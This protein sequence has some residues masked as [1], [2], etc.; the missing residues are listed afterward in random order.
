MTTQVLWNDVDFVLKAPSAS[1]R[2][3]V[4]FDED[5]LSSAEDDSW[6][7]ALYEDLDSGTEYLSSDNDEDLILKEEESYLLDQNEDEDSDD[8]SILSPQTQKFLL[9]YY[10]QNQ[11]TQTH[12]KSHSSTTFEIGE[13]IEEELLIELNQS[14]SGSTIELAPTCPP[15]S[16]RRHSVHAQPVKSSECAL[17][18]LTPQVLAAICAATKPSHK[19]VTIAEIDPHTDYNTADET[20][21]LWSQIITDDEEEE[22]SVTEDE[23][24]ESTSN[25]S[26]FTENDWY[27]YKRIPIN[28]FYKSR[29]STSSIST[30]PSNIPASA[31]RSRADTYI[32]SSFP[33]PRSM[34]SESSPNQDFTITSFA[35]SDVSA[36]GGKVNKNSLYEL[37]ADDHFYWKGYL[38]DII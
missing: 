18:D 8:A 10:G 35:S 16:G 38:M 6:F 26:I 36:P 19:V 32:T 23:D 27:R 29:K 2:S 17:A 22:L 21:S 9:D 34:S 11:K 15:I 3:D 24:D 33:N 28:A 4:L 25:A 14:R 30:K 1:G 31:I 7:E 20:L 13:E 12:G 5:Q 37:D